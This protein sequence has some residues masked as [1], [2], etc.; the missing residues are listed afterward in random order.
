MP[1]ISLSLAISDSVMPSSRDSSRSASTSGLNGSTASACTADG[2]VGS[3]SRSRE[4]SQMPMTA[5]TRP[6]AHGNHL[7]VGLDVDDDDALFGQRDPAAF[8][9]LAQRALERRCG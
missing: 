8:G 4:I 6:R 1:S 5:T 7:A 2:I 3:L 9:E